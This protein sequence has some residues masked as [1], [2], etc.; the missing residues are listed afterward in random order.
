MKIT[1]K[2]LKEMITEAVKAKLNEDINFSA[3]RNVILAAQ[4]ASVSFENEI[5]KTFGLV[6]PD[7]LP[8]KLQQHY[9]MVVKEM[10]QGIVEAVE[11]AV[12]ELVRFPK[13]KNK[14]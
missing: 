3:K 8:A 10:E 4:H 12:R 5:I 14:Q 6:H 11:V 1:E 9:Y 13:T 7:K 2:E